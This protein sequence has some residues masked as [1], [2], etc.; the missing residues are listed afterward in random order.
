MTFDYSLRHRPALYSPN[1]ITFIGRVVTDIWYTL[2]TATGDDAILIPHGHNPE[3][4]I[5]DCA[6]VFFENRA[7][8]LSI[9]VLPWERCLPISPTGSENIPRISSNEIGKSSRENSRTEIPM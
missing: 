9:R 1:N 5:V 7:I 8:Q 3:E 6:G 4:S 2:E